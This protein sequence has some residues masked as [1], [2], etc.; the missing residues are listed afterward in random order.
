[1]VNQIT[2]NASQVRLLELI[3]CGYSNKQIARNIGYTERTV[4]NKVA[5]LMQKL[6]ANN[7][8]HAVVIG[9]QNEI[10]KLSEVNSGI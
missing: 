1:M 3:A 2:I 6:N 10:I 7:R 4:T 9:L 5:I 8:T